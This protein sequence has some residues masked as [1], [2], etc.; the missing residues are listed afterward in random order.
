MM[1][2]FVLTSVLVGLLF[3]VHLHTPNLNSRGRSVI[4][5][6]DDLPLPWLGHA[7]SVFSLTALFGT[8]LAILLLFGLSAAGGLTVG[9]VLALFY[10]RSVCLAS[11]EDCFD[12]F[13]RS[14]AF[15]VRRADNLI[16]WS[17]L[18]ITQIGLAV[19]ELVI[20][21]D[22]GIRA[23]ELAPEHA[24]ALAFFVSLVGYY[25]CLI[26]GYAAVF[27]TDIV[28]IVLVAVMACVVGIHLLLYPPSFAGLGD[29]EIDH[30]SR[31]IESIQTSS[32]AWIYEPAKM[33]IGLIM[34]FGFLIANPDSWKRVFLTTSTGNRKRSSFLMLILAGSAP[35]LLLAPLGAY[36]PSEVLLMD[37]PFAQFFSKADWFVST[38]ILLGTAAAFLSTF[39]GA[40]VVST[41]VGLL[42]LWKDQDGS[43]KKSSYGFAVATVYL[44]VFCATVALAS[45]VQNP[46]LLANILLA[47]FAV[48]AAL[49]LGTKGM[50]K[51]LR[52]EVPLWLSF[53]LTAAM[54][55]HVLAVE[56]VLEK[57]T[58]EQV[59]TAPW[60]AFIFL[61]LTSV[62]WL[63]LAVSRGARNDL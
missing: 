37:E 3:W 56:Q 7:S 19:S 40:L 18:V 41:H 6:D 22:M 43:R 44:V 46:Y 34:G 1:K 5:E 63:T 49:V 36:I 11:E 32:F 28:Q 12:S 20:F 13:L 14:R 9:S 21:R 58:I 38:A 53:V 33:V 55:L 17:L 50:S 42:H 10:L 16:F 23:L 27:R 8:Y 15:S 4:D 62:C 59:L 48:M 57:P 25:Y 24:T 47:P 54:T 51:P 30:F 45:A 61:V 31:V 26:G 52:S 39:D 29:L 35:F 2:A 60:G